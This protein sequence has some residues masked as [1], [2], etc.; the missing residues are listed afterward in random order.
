MLAGSS[1]SVIERGGTT[2]VYGDNRTCHERTLFGCQKDCNPA[3]GYYP[4][5]HQYSFQVTFWSR[6]AFKIGLMQRNENIQPKTSDTGRS[7]DYHILIEQNQDVWN[8]KLE[9]SITGEIVVFHRPIDLVRWLE[10]RAKL[11]KPQPGLA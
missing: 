7:S 6:W 3:F 2:T 1:S 5:A 10:R 4:K 11:E 9:D 8:A